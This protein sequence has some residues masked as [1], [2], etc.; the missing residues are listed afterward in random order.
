LESG[1][2]ILP[3]LNALLNATSA[4]FL[5]IGYRRIRRSE[6]LRHRAMMIAAAITSL[7]FL[8]SYTTYHWQHGTTRF[9]GEGVVRAVYMAI[10]TTHTLLAMVVAP[11]VVWV[12]FLAH[13]GRF[14]RH[15]AAA[16]WLFPMW[17]Y[18]SVTGIVVY[19]LLY[20]YPR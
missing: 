14:E 2:R 13:R 10:L 15:R 7:V 18:V 9:A 12:L 1:W 11:L 6:I 8:L 16:R 4:V 3:T 20:H 19:L 17:L 5:V